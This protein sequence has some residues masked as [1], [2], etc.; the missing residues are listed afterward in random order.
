[1]N[2]YVNVCMCACVVCE[3]EG[4]MVGVVFVVGGV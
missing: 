1:V 2:V 3:G 4:M